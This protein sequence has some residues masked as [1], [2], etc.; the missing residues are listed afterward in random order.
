MQR[1]VPLALSVH[2]ARYLRWARPLAQHV[3]LARPQ[4]PSRVSAHCALLVTTQL[5][6]PHHAL[7]VHLAR[8]LRSA[9][10]LAQHVLLA[11]TQV[12]SRVSAHCALLV[13]TQLLVPLALSVRLAPTL[14][15]LDL[16]LAWYAPRA[17]PLALEHSSASDL[18]YSQSCRGV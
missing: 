6:V 5:L 7:S 14:Q 13:T 18:P 11:L 10:P 16:Q 8:Y 3:L 15:P 12:S 1:L 4:V 2:L 17:D 9:R